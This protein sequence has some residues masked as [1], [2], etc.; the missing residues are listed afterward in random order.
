MRCL[1]RRIERLTSNESRGRTG[2]TPADIPFDK[3]VA[4]SSIGADKD[5]IDLAATERRVCR[6]VSTRTCHAKSCLRISRRT[7]LLRTST[8]SA[9]VRGHIISHR[10]ALLTYGPL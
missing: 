5:I 9:A 2:R 10:F 4:G 7:V 1:V 8:A 3:G 6:A